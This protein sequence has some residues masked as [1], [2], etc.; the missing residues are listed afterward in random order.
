MKSNLIDKIGLGFIIFIIAIL[1]IFVGINSFDPDWIIQL[2]I[3][4]FTIIYYVV[5]KIK[6]E[7][8]IILK[9]KIDI[10]VLIFMI[11]TFI[12]F[13]FHSYASLNE[14]VD[15][16]I[17]YWSVYGFYILIRNIINNGE[18]L[19][20][21]GNTFLISSMILIVVGFDMFFGFYFIS[22]PI[23]NLLNM[24]REY[25]ETYRMVSLF[26]YPNTYAI[27]LSVMVSFAIA[28]FLNASNKKTK[29]LYILYI[30]LA[31]ISIILTESKGTLGVIALIILAFIL[32]GIKKKIISKK[33]VILGIVAIVLFFIYFFI[34]IQI[35]KPLE[36]YGEKMCVIRGI[37]S[38]TT[39]ELEFDMQ[40]ESDKQENC[41]EIKIDQITRYLKAETIENIQFDDSKDN[42]KVTITTGSEIDHLEIYFINQQN[43]KLTINDFKIN[44]ERYVLEYKIIPGNI[45]RIITNFNF[46][47]SSTWQRAD[48]WLDGIDMIK[49]HCILGNGGN[50]Y[51]IMY[52]QVQEYNYEN[53]T[54]V[55][56]DI[57]N[58]WISFGLVGFLAYIFMLKLSIC[59][60]IKH[61]KDKNDIKSYRIYYAALI[62]I[63][64]LILHGLIDADMSFYLTKI[65]VFVII[66]ILTKE[67][68]SIKFDKI[69]WIEN[70][71]M[72]VFAVISIGN[73]L[74]IGAK[75]FGASDYT[76]ISKIAPWKIEY[77]TQDMGRDIIEKEDKE[78]GIKN[79]IKYLKEEPYIEQSYINELLTTGIVSSMNDEGYEKNKKY[80]E[81]F[82][83]FWKNKKL[84]HKFNI[85]DIKNQM[86]N[87]FQLLEMLEIRYK[88]E[89]IEEIREKEE[90]IIELAKK[91]YE[92]YSEVILN[93]RRYGGTE[94]NSQI[95]YNN[96]T[97]LYNKVLAV[98][99]N[100]Q[101]D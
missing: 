45:V 86:E 82:I 38:N 11:A 34:A 55:H 99:D 62:S 73:V 9:G 66:A 14:T 95:E 24:S 12:P 100:S 17:K 47:Y 74:V 13:L 23:L 18:K 64:M 89:D 35:A 90:E 49:E 42:I 71:I 10:A 94:E 60:G 30:L 20:I 56:N 25:Y 84:S 68:N 54:E 31:V 97:D 65:L 8:N 21:L 41:F 26:G 57:L 101:I 22:S 98:K 33:F 15:T 96:Y 83:D 44:G 69:N 93:Y 76:K 85:E 78:E 81:F 36:I 77:R 92:I 29:I 53:T 72:I 16:F 19:K 80:V 3:C 88:I 7:K 70:I 58:M 28:L 40:A 32:I 50:A 46:S 59:A 27:Y 87:N 6:K 48:Y 37:K 79:V 67:D 4:V 5:K 61:L 63:I 75:I 39:Y 43:Q 2:S 51:K 91:E 52:P 1:N